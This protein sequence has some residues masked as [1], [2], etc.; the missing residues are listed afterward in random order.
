MALTENQEKIMEKIMNKIK[1]YL[2]EDYKTATIKYQ[3]IQ[4][5]N[6]EVLNGMIIRKEGHDLAVV[7]YLELF[8]Q[9]IESGKSFDVVMKK[10]A[11]TYISE[12]IPNDLIKS[13]TTDILNY[14]CVKGKIVCKLVNLKHNTE[15]LKD[16]IYS[17]VSDLAIIYQIIVAENDSGNAAQTITN[18]TFKEYGITKKE[19]HQQAIQNMKKQGYS[20]EKL[21]LLTFRS[22]DDGLWILSNQNYINGAAMILVPKIQK[23]IKSKLGDCYVLPSSI[24]E[25]LLLPKRYAFDRHLMDIM[26][27][28]AN[29]HVSAEEYL[30]DHVYELSDFEKIEL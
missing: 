29:K 15:Y 27:Q 30:S 12:E 28:D 21:N 19:L 2:P 11:N 5:N 1:D 17:T 23:M 22:E 20:F 25:L 8:I 9:E 7:V 16:K 18:K 3:Q 24:Q 4:K 14:D 10:L 6:D 26:V 13:F